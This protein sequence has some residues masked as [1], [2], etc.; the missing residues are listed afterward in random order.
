M[1]VLT[2]LSFTALVAALPVSTDPSLQNLQARANPDQYK[3][4][5]G[6]GST[7]QGWPSKTQWYVLLDT[8]PL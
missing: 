1:Q 7:Q 6:D 2:A 3:L 5:L 8:F 4:Y